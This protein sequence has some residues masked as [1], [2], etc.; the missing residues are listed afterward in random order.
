M[1]RFVFAAALA[2]SGCGG[3]FKQAVAQYSDHQPEY[4]QA[5]GVCQPDSSGQ[6]SE[7]CL[8]DFA[9]PMSGL[10]C[11]VDEDDGRAT[12]RACECARAT[13]ATVRTTKCTA[14]LKVGN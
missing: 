7:D 3:P 6:Y 5:I 8:R 10:R 11:L 4:T 12:S 2:C 14:W 1:K 9:F 13:S